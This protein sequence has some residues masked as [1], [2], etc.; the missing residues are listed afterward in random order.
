MLGEEAEAQIPRGINI[1]R[2]IDVTV[3]VKIGPSDFVRFGIL[4][5]W[6]TSPRNVS[7]NEPIQTFPDALS[8]LT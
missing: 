4:A 8:G 7:N 2:V 5:Q 6:N 3:G 1:R